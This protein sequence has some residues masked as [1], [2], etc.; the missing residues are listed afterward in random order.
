MNSLPVAHKPLSAS[1]MYLTKTA[2]R[3]VMNSLVTEIVVPRYG[4]AWYPWAVQYFFLVA[5]SYCTLWLSAPGLLG[6]KN[7]RNTT[8]VALL[9]CVSTTR[10]EEHTSELQSRPHLVCR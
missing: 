5:L 6:A 9:A 3:S 2:R 8:R 10:S 1:G 4:L 7:W